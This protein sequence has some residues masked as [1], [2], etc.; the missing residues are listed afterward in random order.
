MQTI[1]GRATHEQIP[2]VDT[3]RWWPSRDGL[4]RHSLR[5]LNHVDRDLDNFTIAN[6]P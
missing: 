4:F 5:S 1:L 3:V 6:F 2:L